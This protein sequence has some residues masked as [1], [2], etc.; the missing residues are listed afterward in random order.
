[1]KLELNLFFYVWNDWE[2]RELHADTSKSDSD[3]R[4]ALKTVTVEIPDGIDFTET[5]YQEAQYL[6]GLSVA[7]K[8]VEEK[9]K[10]LYQAEEIVK[11][12]LALPATVSDVVISNV[13]EDDDLDIPF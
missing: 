13:D 1:M 8:R 10:E 12:M 9:R 6:K 11:N 7:E 5:K 4:L 3:H 2:K